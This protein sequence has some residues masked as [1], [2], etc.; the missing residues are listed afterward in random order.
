MSFS[1]FARVPSLLSS[2]RKQ[3]DRSLASASSL[4]QQDGP[5]PWRGR[6]LAKGH[7]LNFTQQ[8]GL[9]RLGQLWGSPEGSVDCESVVDWPSFEPL[10]AK[11]TRA[12]CMP[13]ILMLK[14]PY[15][16]LTAPPKT[17]LSLADAEILGCLVDLSE[18]Q[19]GHRLTL[20]F[21]HPNAPPT[22]AVSECLSPSKMVW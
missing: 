13:R 16:A 3:P 18:H 10:C 14:V 17:E 7:C 6:G 20:H 9:H 15:K 22:P 19:L 11:P 1:Q 2:V 5:P 8:W 4:A 12:R 21:F